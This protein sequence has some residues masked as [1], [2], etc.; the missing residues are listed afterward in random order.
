LFQTHVG[1]RRKFFTWKPI[2]KCNVTF[3]N[4]A[5]GNIICRVVNIS[6]GRGRAKNML[7]FYG[8]KNNL[9]SVSQMYG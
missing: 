5:R 7:F 8:L 9:L 4:N 2:G 3:G 1:D 6:N